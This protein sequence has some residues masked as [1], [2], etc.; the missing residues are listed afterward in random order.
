MANIFNQITNLI[1]QP[2][3][4]MVYHLVIAFIFISILQPALS[5]IATEDKNQ[6]KR[7]FHCVHLIYT[8]NLRSQQYPG[9]G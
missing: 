8:G 4:S 5:F 9:G 2:S 6:R 7:L 1:V 3:G